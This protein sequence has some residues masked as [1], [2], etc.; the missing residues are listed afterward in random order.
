MDGYGIRRDMLCASRIFIV[1]VLYFGCCWFIRSFVWFFPVAFFYLGCGWSSTYMK[2]CQYSHSFCSKW[3]NWVVVSI[4][5]AEEEKHFTNFKTMFFRID[6]RNPWQKKE[7][8]KQKFSFLQLLTCSFRSFILFL[9]TRY[10]IKFCVA[11]VHLTFHVARV[12]SF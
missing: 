12:T 1:A 6:D 11:S 2:S 10:N 5:D 7:K 3:M 4:V 9:S 8:N